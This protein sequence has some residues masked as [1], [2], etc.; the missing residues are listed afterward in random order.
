MKHTF[1][2]DENVIVRGLLQK[3][4]AERDLLLLIARNCHHIVVSPP[5]YDKYW[6]KVRAMRSRSGPELATLM[7]ALLSQLLMNKD[8]SIWVQPS[9]GESPG[10]V[11]RDMDDWFLANIAAAVTSSVNVSECIVVTSDRST[12]DDF[13]RE[14][15]QRAGIQGATIERACEFAMQTDG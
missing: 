10:S 7:T 14:E 4:K 11:V 1:L 8:K 5:L 3:H 6:Q 9:T 15:M 13:N 2:L 12:R